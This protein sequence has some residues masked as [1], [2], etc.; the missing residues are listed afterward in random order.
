MH[1]AITPT[2]SLS[3]VKTK[4]LACR[5]SPPQSATVN[6]VMKE[7]IANTT[8]TNASQYR[9]RTMDHAR[10]LLQL[11]SVIARELDLLAQFVK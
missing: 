4:V 1:F 11:L 5:T 2:V 8:S 10:I 6:W 7:N 9:A 3:N